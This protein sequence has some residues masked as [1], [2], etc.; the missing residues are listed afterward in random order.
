MRC[1]C[2]KIGFEFLRVIFEFFDDVLNEEIML[3]GMCGHESLSFLEF[4]LINLSFSVFIF[5]YF[6]EEKLKKV[7][8]CDLINCNTGICNR[9]SS[10]KKLKIN[11]I[12]AD[13]LHIL[14]VSC[15]ESHSHYF[16]WTWDGWDIISAL[17]MFSRCI[18]GVQRLYSLVTKLSAVCCP[19]L[20]HLLDCTPAIVGVYS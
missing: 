16:Y 18:Q 2:K 19:A 13:C 14:G 5:R 11:S 12:V 4:F 17:S 3:T 6:W 15:A 1:D 9:N 7:F 20:Q 8:R 10:F